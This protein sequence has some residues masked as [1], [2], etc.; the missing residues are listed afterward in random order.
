MRMSQHDVIALVRCPKTYLPLATTSPNR[1]VRGDGCHFYPMVN[2]I[3]ILLDNRRSIWREDD[4]LAGRQGSP[5]AAPRKQLSWSV[6]S[7]RALQRISRW[8]SPTQLPESRSR[9][10]RLAT[11]LRA[12]QK[13]HRPKVLI[14]GGARLGSGSRALVDAPDI[15]IL[16]ADIAAGSRTQVVCDAH[17]LPFQEETFDAVVC[18]AVLEHV[19]D[20]AAVVGEIRRVLRPHGFVYSEVPFMQQV[21]GGAY[22]FTRF[23]YVGHRRLWRWF[24]EI[25]SGIHGGPAMALAWSIQYFVR[26]LPRRR[27]ARAMVF[28]IAGVFLSW[29]PRM[30]SFLTSRRAAY[31]AAAGSYFLGRLAEAP[32]SDRELVS[33]YRG[34]T[35]LQ[36]PAEVIGHN[37]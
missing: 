5:V 10:E 25:E 28:V 26:A 14:V 35:Q 16:E 27:R 23:T 3:P 37:T 15:D 19:A 1:L 36:A 12:S 11:Q 2:G 17:A 29:L 8:A 21:H 20:P 32:I 13:G 30:D 6:L 9:Y 34:G 22:D 24:D 4:Y 7:Y 18:Q 31:D 33:L